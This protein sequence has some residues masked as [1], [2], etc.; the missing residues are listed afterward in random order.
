MSGKRRKYTPGDDS[1]ELGRFDEVDKAQLAAEL[2][3]IEDS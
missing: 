3:D 2:R 1:E